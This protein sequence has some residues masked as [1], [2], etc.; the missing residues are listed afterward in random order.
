MSTPLTD[1]QRRALELVKQSDFGEEAARVNA[2]IA[3][4]APQ[5]ISA[6]TRL[7]RCHLEQRNWDEAVTALRT[8]LSLNPSHTIATNLLNEVRK[9]RALTPTA[10]QRSMTGFGTREFAM[11]SS[12][13]A[14]EACAAL[15][16]RID[17]LLETLNATDTAARIVS[18]RHAAGATGSKLFH[19]N[20][21]VAH[22]IG[23]IYVF[24]HG[25][26][27]EP[28]FN[29][30]WFSSPPFPSSCVRIGLGFNVAPAGVEAGQESAL[31]S[32]ERF[33]RTLEKSWKR[34]LARWMADNGGFIQ[35]GDRPPSTCSP[36]RPSSG[37]S[38]AT[39]P[40]R[41]NGSSSAAGCFST[42]PTMRELWAT[43]RGSGKQWTTRS[44]RST[45]SGWERIA[46]IGVGIVCRNAPGA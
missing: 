27:F 40:R 20:S 34:E 7:G 38:T 37:C 6:W 42:S 2:A 10:A 32:Y 17:M 41:S 30:G 13:S 24:Q 46:E 11:L 18:A 12:L 36:T 26:R 33:Q 5:D 28:Q 29:I 25:G 19:A 21:P 39:T 14:S 3:E 9:Q 22:S 43:G 35:Y 45:R 16:S 44:G 8:A 1:L 4:Q 31:G 15:Q 23:H